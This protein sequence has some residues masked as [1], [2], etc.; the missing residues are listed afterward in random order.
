MQ[1]FSNMGLYA[2]KPVF[3]VCEH[4]RRPACPSS[5]SDQHL[6]CSLFGKYHILTCFEQKFNF[7]A[8]LCSRVDW[9]EPYLSE[10]PKTGFLAS[11]SCVEAHIISCAISISNNLENGMFRNRENLQDLITA[12]SFSLR[13]QEK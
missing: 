10:T 9:F 13:V 11:L 12:E 8:S 5:Q 4:R 6:C 1:H 7:L 2:S 3:G